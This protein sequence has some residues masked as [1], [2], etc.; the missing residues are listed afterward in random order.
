MSAQTAVEWE[1]SGG[2]ADVGNRKSRLLSSGTQLS[3]ARMRESH[4][5]C[6][7]C[8]FTIWS[9]PVTNTRGCR[10]SLRGGVL[11]ERQRAS[12]RCSP[13]PLDDLGIRAIEQSD[14]RCHFRKR[15]HSESGSAEERA[16]IWT[17]SD[18]RH[19]RV[20]PSRLHIT[21]SVDWCRREPVV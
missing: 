20:T 7:M 15:S 16:K 12:L 21:A 4:A 8:D 18:S 3:F 10:T 14:T 17:V 5:A 19:W 9:C 2:H 6:E 1:G 13:Q 11:V